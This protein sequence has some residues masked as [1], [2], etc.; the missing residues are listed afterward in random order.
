MGA[1][2]G[3]LELASAAERT[4]A[5]LPLLVRLARRGALLASLLSVA[6]YLVVASQRMAYPFELEWMEGGMVDAVRRLLAGQPLY[7]PPSLEYVPFIYAPLYFYVSAAASAV[8]GVGFLPLRFVSFAASLGQFALLFLLAR[9]TAGSAVAGLLSVGLYAA[10]YRLSGAWLDVGRVDSLFL[11]LLLFGVF[12]HLRASSWR[13]SALAGAS[14]GLAFLAKQTALLA[15]APLVA[16][17]L[18]T[19]RRQAIALLASLLG[20]AVLPSLALEL[21]SG[22]WFRYY[23]FDLPGQ[24]ELLPSMLV[25]F[26]LGDLALPLPLACAL[27]VA[28]LAGA[29]RAARGESSA[30]W[31]ALGIGLVGGAWASRL[32]SGGWANVLLPA[33]AYLALLFG[34]GALAA[35]RWLTAWRSG[36]GSGEGRRARRAA[37]RRARAPGGGPA[38]APRPVDGGAEREPGPVRP[39][40]AAEGLLWLACLA[41]LGLLGWNP[42]AQLPSP[43]DLQA[44]RHLLGLLAAIEGEVYLPGTGYLSSLAGKATY[45]QSQALDDVLRGRGG[46]ARE[47]LVEEVRSAILSQRF[48]AVVLGDN[49]GWLREAVPEFD[50]YYVLNA[51]VFDDPTVF[52]PVTGARARPQEV[53]RPAGR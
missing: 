19:R 13:G 47:R 46:P 36:A 33:Y 25:Y 18:V 22:G 53:Y 52:W 4:G 1:H 34:P 50:H 48:A 35:Q 31:L 37:G 15:A 32:H 24:H 28:A 40:L 10:L 42:S 38:P 29:G 23:V 2:H 14:L 51:R 30:R 26:W 6:A 21:S 20:V 16:L 12:L 44:G 27:A 7:V 11:C 39:S 45:A 8:L 9:R 41:Q 49:D 5:G 3:G 43:A 17:E